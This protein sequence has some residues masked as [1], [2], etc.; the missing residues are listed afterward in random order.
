[1]IGSSSILLFKLET[2]CQPQKTLTKLTTTTEDFCRRPNGVSNFHRTILNPTIVNPRYYTLR[3]LFAI[4]IMGY[5]SMSV[6]YSS[7]YVMAEDVRLY[8]VTIHFFTFPLPR[9]QSFPASAKI[10][11]FVFPLVQ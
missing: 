4:T 1:L 9:T 3:Q 5:V 11:F 8:H 2:Q 10:Y 7:K 6:Y